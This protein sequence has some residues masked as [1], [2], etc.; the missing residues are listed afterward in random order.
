MNE[1]SIRMD[2]LLADL[3]A[4]LVVRYGITPRDAVGM[5]MQSPVAER[6]RDEN[7]ELFG[8]SIEQL[9]AQM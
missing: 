7:S 5:V 6:L 8:Y 9:A 1:T 3:S 2:T 4:Y